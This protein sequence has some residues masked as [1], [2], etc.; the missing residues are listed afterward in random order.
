MIVINAD[1]SNRVFGPS[2]VLIAVSSGL[3]IL[4]A[5]ILPRLARLHSLINP[6]VKF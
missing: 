6:A 4:E 3:T 1:I 5:E 2:K